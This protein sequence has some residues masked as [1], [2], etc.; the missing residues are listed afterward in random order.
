M[1]KNAITTWFYVYT[2]N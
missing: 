1:P 2:L